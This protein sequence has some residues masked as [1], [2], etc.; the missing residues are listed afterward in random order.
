MKNL[1]LIAAASLVV[2]SCAMFPLFEERMTSCEQMGISRDTYYKV[3]MDNDR[4]DRDRLFQY[5]KNGTKV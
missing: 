2:T 3:E 4:E 1:I 5:A